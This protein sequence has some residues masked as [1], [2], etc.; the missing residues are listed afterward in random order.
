VRKLYLPLHPV[1]IL[2][3]YKKTN[4]RERSFFVIICILHNE[5]VN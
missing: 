2:E 5:W 4:K 3:Y 1:A